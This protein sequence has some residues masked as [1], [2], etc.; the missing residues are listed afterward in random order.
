V[1]PTRFWIDTDTAGDDV[2][3]LLFGLLWPDVTLEGISVVAGN[4]YLEE[5]TRNALYTTEIARRTDVPVFAG[6]D[7][8][9][10]R[11]PFTA[12]YVHGR[13]GMGDSD[14]PAPRVQARAKHSVQALIDAARTHG[15][16]LV[17]I[18][19]GPLKNL[20]LALREAPEIPRQMGPVW[21]MGGTNNSLG[22]VTPAAEFNFYVDPEAAH[23]VLRAGFDVTLVP[24]DVCL[25]HGVLERAELQPILDMGTE[26]S[27]FY[28]RVNRTA[29]EFMRT[30]GGGASVD[31]IG[32]PDALTI[33]MAIEPRLVTGRGRYHVDVEHRGELTRGY[34]VVDLGGVL[35]KAPNAD[36]IL[37]ADKPSFR[38]MVFRL[39]ST[40]A[41]TPAQ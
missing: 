36:V 38:D 12:N 5:A 35:R 6:A 33:A 27:E 1:S 30:R 15:R 11:P 9:L 14:F 31:G 19:Q 41:R 16:D 13:D 37:S 7:R 2:T 21:I 32:H 26:L 22:N 28:L 8:P 20:A 24:W 10:L 3:S 17:L 39:L 18:A 34:S 25:R 40:D 4:V 23:M 29:W